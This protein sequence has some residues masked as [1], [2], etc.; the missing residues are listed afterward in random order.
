MGVE[1]QPPPVP[2]FAPSNWVC[3]VDDW[4]RDGAVT[5]ARGA[6]TPS[7]EETKARHLLGGSRCRLDAWRTFLRRD[8]HTPSPPSAQNQGARRE[9]WAL[10]WWIQITRILS[11][12]QIWG[13]VRT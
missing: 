3:E 12:S 5:S 10:F 11:L 8:H 1:V 6:S 2:E 13:V 4:I 9:F 7:K